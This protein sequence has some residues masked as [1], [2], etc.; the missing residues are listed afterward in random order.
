[1]MRDSGTAIEALSQDLSRLRRRAAQQKQNIETSADAWQRWSTTM[2]EITALTQRLVD[3]PAPDPASLADKF[4][5]ILWLIE[6]NES[7]LD[8]GDLRRLRRFGRELSFSA[9]K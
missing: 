1:M 8:S 4:R 9:R 3:F 2:D 5:A 6:V 7:L